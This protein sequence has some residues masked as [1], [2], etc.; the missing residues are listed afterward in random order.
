MIDWSN[1][2]VYSKGPSFYQKVFAMPAKYISPPAGTKSIGSYEAK[3][4]LPQILRQVQAG[5]IFEISVRGQAVARLVPAVALA[6]Q[7]ESASSKMREFMRVQISV[8]AGAGMD[9]R[10]MLEDGRA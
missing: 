3:T 9:L 4:H 2:L 7:R 1:H 5:Q 10:E 8:S 6:Q